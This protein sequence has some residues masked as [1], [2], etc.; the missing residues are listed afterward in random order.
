M[1]LTERDTEIL[2]A[3]HTFGFLT[4]LQIAVLFGMHLKV[5]QRRLRLLSKGGYLGRVPIPT[6]KAGR[7]PNLFYLGRQAEALLH[8]RSA[9]PRLE[10]KTSH[11]MKNADILIQVALS[12]R[13]QGLECGLL[14]EHTIRVAGLEVIPDGAFMLKRDGRSALFL[15]ENCAGTEIVRSPTYNQD[16]ETKIIRYT[17]IFEKNEIGFYKDYFECGLR[18]FR[19][20]Y[21]TN[22][23]T[24]LR[25]ISSV[26]L[27]HDIHG[28]VWLTTLGKLK[29]GICANIWNV[30]AAERFNVPITG[31]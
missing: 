16:I 19:L 31:E 30:P 8:V 27:E 10:R 22:N 29:K 7:S 6:V 15:L 1:R 13:K 18:R 21:I 17:E 9:C 3:V 5:C 14:P 25:A 12:C 28:F 2:K 26:V 11:A 4:C 24:R 23:S 20:L